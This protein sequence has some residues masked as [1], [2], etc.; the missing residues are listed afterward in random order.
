MFRYSTIDR[1]A[2]RVKNTVSNSAFPIPPFFNTPLLTG[3]PIEYN[4]YP[5]Q[6][7]LT[8]TYSGVLS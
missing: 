6:Q 8:S 7:R 3:R 5:E 2:N 1:T 4:L